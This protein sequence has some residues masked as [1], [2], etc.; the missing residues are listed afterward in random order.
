MKR[1]VTS[2]PTATPTTSSTATSVTTTPPAAAADPNHDG[3]QSVS[4]RG[5]RLTA[6][7]LVAGAVVVNL[8]F[9]GLGSVI[10]YPDVL[11][12]PA[13]DVLADFHENQVVIGALFLLLAAGAGLLAP[14][15][16]RVGRLGSSRALRASVPVGVAAAAVQV[17]GLLRWPTLVPGLASDAGSASAART[18]DT[19]NLVLG[20]VVGETFGYALTAVWTV[21]VAVGLRRSLLGLPLAI[22]GIASAAMVAVGVVEPLNV[23][24]AGLV[25]FFG[26]LVWSA[27]L[28]AVAVA[29]IRS[30]R[31]VAA[32]S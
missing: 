10:N 32:A 18:F 11:N 1:S 2:I 8:A 27:W 25:N 30:G 9:L 5:R 14:I 26:Y 15:A 6:L 13:A 19:L 7:L 23:L 17:I 22:V 24:G 21:L 3:A 16:I 29:V 4:I 12:E 20:T 31:S 28:V